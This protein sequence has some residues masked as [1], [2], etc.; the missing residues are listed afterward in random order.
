MKKE[1]AL[2]ELKEHFPFFMPPPKKKAAM[3]F[4]DT[5]SSERS[6]PN[7]LPL[8]MLVVKCKDSF[9]LWLKGCVSDDGWVGRYYSHIFGKKVEVYQTQ[10]R[11]FEVAND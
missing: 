5:V 1:K 9:D 8:N 10:E 11:R 2:E 4:V 7:P 3:H 6:V